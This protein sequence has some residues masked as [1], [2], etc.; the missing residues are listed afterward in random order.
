[1]SWFFYCYC[2]FSS[3]RHYS[4]GKTCPSTSYFINWV[5]S[6]K[7]EDT[8]T[9]NLKHQILHLNLDSNS[10][11]TSYVA[12]KKEWL[13]W[14][15]VLQPLNWQWKYQ[16][17][18]VFLWGWIK[19]MHLKCLTQYLAHIHEMKTM[20]NIIHEFSSHWMGRPKEEY[21]WHLPSAGRIG[22]I[23]EISTKIPLCYQELYLPSGIKYFTWDS[24]D[25]YMKLSLYISSKFIS[26][27]TYL[28][29]GHKIRML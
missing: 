4:L 7:K 26:R 3:Y 11:S 5:V 14:S 20:I 15:S 16:K 19:F 10:D 2:F 28:P 18:R 23:G 27:R 21:V 13:L 6:R 24:L 12:W 29:S 22:P 8:Q 25:K 9:K 1:M 17:C